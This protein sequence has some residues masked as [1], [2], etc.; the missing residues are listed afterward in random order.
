MHDLNAD[1]A[2]EPNTQRF[3]SNSVLVP[4]EGEPV[5]VSPFAGAPVTYDLTVS[6]PRKPTDGSPPRVTATLIRETAN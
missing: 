4:A 6:A 1:V 2:T 3:L 5:F